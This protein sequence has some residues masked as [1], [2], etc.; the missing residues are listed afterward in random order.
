MSASNADIAYEKISEMITKG[1]L[2]PGTRIMEAE[3]AARIGLSRTP[4]RE[5]IRK[6]ENKGVIVH[7]PRIGAAVRKLSH[8]EIVELYEMRIV[9]ERT[10]AS[11]AARH[12]SIGELQLLTSLNN[13]MHE[14][15]DSRTI[16]ELNTA[17]HSAI[18]A[19]ARNQFLIESYRTL[20]NVLLLLGSTTLGKA[21]RVKAAYQ[22]HAAI[23]EA[24]K[25]SNPIK[26]ADMM[27]A[28]MN[29]SLAERLKALT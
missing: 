18:F 12:I 22:E 21:Q 5:A 6:L 16:A 29:N 10:A 25:E 26:A 9:L 13:D 23:I 17:F 2:K 3:I 7:K 28:H 8:Q 14:A 4:V 1:D 20:A 19:S 27:E 11:M 24:I 15:N